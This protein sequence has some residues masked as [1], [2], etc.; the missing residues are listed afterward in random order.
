MATQAAAGK[1]TRTL[2]VSQ[3]TILHQAQRVQGLVEQAELA[4]LVVRGELEEL[5]G[6]VEQQLKD[7]SKGKPKGK[8]KAKRKAKRRAKAKLLWSPEAEI[9]AM[10]MPSRAR[11]PATTEILIPFW[12]PTPVRSTP[13]LRKPKRKAASPAT[14]RKAK[15][16]RQA[17]RA[18]VTVTKPKRRAR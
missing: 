17:C 11:T 4:V 6:L 10:K 5:V 9:V 13:L 3:L 8:S 14:T 16:R 18:A 15:Q 7:S 2:P 1:V 12:E